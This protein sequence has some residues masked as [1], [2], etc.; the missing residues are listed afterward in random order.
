MTAG[1]AFWKRYGIGL[2]D[3]V[4]RKLYNGNALKLL[5]RLPRGPFGA[6]AAP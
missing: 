6:P 3:P 5:S 4:L 1:H 2:P